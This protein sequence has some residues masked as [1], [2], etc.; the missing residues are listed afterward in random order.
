MVPEYGTARI[1]SCLQ[2]YSFLLT[3]SK[4]VKISQKCL[5]CL[6]KARVV[7]YWEQQPFWAQVS[8]MEQH[9]FVPTTH[10]ISCYNIPIS[11]KLERI[12][13]AS[14]KKYLSCET[15]GGIECGV[16]YGVWTQ[17]HIQSTLNTQLHTRF[18]T[19]RSILD[20]DSTRIHAATPMQLGTILS[21]F[22]FMQR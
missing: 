4:M 10:L 14:R 22:L 16:R 7:G 9:H 19:P 6:P 12:K 15:E 18:K 2:F 13:I 17:L 11:R 8:S 3:Y 21:V 1:F 5:T 20:S